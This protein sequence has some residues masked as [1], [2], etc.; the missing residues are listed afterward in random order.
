M[1]LPVATAIVAVRKGLTDALAELD[2]FDDVSVNFAFKIGDK[3]RER[4]WTQDAHFSQSPASLRP[5]RTFRD[6]IGTFA[7]RILIEGVAKDPHWTSSRAATLGAA[8]EN[9]VANHANWNDGALGIEIQTLTIQGDGEL[10]EAFND[11]GSLAELT[12]PIRYTA[13]LV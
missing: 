8:A 9:F 2:A 13:R 4:C 3:K 11:K 5:G 12:Y 7:L 6:E 1:A 10:V